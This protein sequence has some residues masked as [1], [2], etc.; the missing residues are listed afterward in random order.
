MIVVIT[1]G[2]EEISQHLNFNPETTRKGKKLKESGH[3]LDVKEI[4]G[5]DGTTQIQAF[6]VRQASVT[7]PPYKTVLHVSLET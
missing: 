7:L 6:V 1:I 2:F 3:V 4:R 5:D